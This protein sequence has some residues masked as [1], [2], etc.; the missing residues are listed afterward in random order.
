MK[1]IKYIILGIIS[2]L[3]ISCS[4]KLY[5]SSNWDGHFKTYPTLTTLEDKVKQDSIY[6]V[7]CDQWVHDWVYTNKY[8][9]AKNRKPLYAPRT[10]DWVYYR[11]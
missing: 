11:H 10:I 9:F 7:Q 8:D 1:H 6:K 2:T 3:I 5:E 4:P